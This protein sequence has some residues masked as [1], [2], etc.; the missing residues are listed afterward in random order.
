MGD[1][2]FWGQ[3]QQQP[4]FIYAFLEVPVKF[5]RIN[6]KPIISYYPPKYSL[7][8]KY[9]AQIFMAYQ[10]KAMKGIALLADRHTVTCFKLAGL[11]NIFSVEDAKEAEK[12][13]LSLLEKNDLK[14]ILVTKQLMNQIQIFEKIADQ[15]PLIIPIP[16]IQGTT[17]LKTDLLAELIKRK[18]GIE[19]KF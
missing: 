11:S 15:G 2:R 8:F 17:V 9:R 13:L 19:V 7:A 3:R 5:F 4:Q 12:H 6:S 18:T 1:L 14:I 16:D 10:G